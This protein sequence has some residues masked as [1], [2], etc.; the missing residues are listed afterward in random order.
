VSQA[1]LEISVFHRS[2]DDFGV[3]LRFRHPAAG[4]DKSA[5][6][7]LALDE[8]ALGQV[9][10]DAT[11]YGERLAA[12]LFASPG[13]RSFLDQTLAVA[14]SQQ[15]PLHLRLFIHPDATALHAL[16]WETLRLPGSATPL[17]TGEWVRFSRY[18]DS[19]GWRPTRTVERA[20]LRALVAVASPD[21]AGTALAEV[22]ID[23]ELAAA[24]AGLGDIP[25]VELAGRGQVTL[26]ALLARLR[27]GCDILYLAAHGALVDGEPQILLEREDGGRAWTAGSELAARL[28]E[29]ASPPSLVVLVSCQ[30]AGA[31]GQWLAQDGGAL[32]GLGPRL[33]A[34]GVPA[35]VAMQGNLSMDT[36][37]AF[38]PAF[39]RELRRDGQMA[40]AMAVARGAVRARPDW[41]MPVLYTRLED[42]RVFELPNA[43][44]DSLFD[45]PAL[46]QRDLPD[47][48]FHYLDWYPRED[49]EVFFG[50]GKEI[51]SLYDRVTSPDGDPI[52]LLYGQS[53]VGKS[54]VL[55]AGLR[56]RLDASHEVRYMRRDQEKGLLGTLAA[57][58]PIGLDDDLASAWRRLEAQ[59]DRPLLVVVDQVE[60]YFTRPNPKQPHEMA[61][62]LDA[63]QDLFGDASARPRG[64]IILGFRKEWLAEIDKRLAERAL[65]RAGVFLERLGRAGIAEVVAGP[66]SRSRLRSRYGLSVIDALPGMIADDLLADRESPVAPMLAILLADMWDAAKARSYDRPTFDEDLYHEF[67]TRGLSLNDFLG[68]QLRALAGEMPE[69]VD[70][71]L[72]LDLLAYHTTPLGTAEQRTLADLEQTYSHRLDVLPALVQQCQDLYLLVDPAKN[73]PGQPPA[74]RL[75]HD[76]LAP[77]VR[78]RFDESNAPGQ[79]ARR[80]LDGRVVEWRNGADGTIL[81]DIDLATIETGADGM[82]AWN[83]A[84]INMIDASREHRR[85]RAKQRRVQRA[86]GIGAMALIVVVLA[87]AAFFA[88]RSI[89][90]Q[91]SAEI[92]GA[93]RLAL[94]AK[95]AIGSDPESALLLAMEAANAHRS[96]ITTDA[97]REALLA[98]RVVERVN[99]GVQAEMNAAAFSAGQELFAVARLDGKVLLFDRQNGDLIRTLDSGDKTFIRDLAFSPQSS[100]H[101]GATGYRYQQGSL[102]GASGGFAKIWDVKSGA[103]VFSAEFAES[104]ND[105]D[106][107]SDMSTVV[108]QVGD[109]EAQ[110]WD[111]SSGRQITSRSIAPRVHRPTFNTDGSQI[112]AVVSQREI[113]VWDSEL[114]QEL[115]RWTATATDEEIT[116]LAFSPQGDISVM[117]NKGTVSIWDMSQIH[118]PRLKTRQRV[119]EGP[120]FDAVFSPNGACVASFG[121]S[122]QQAVVAT[123]TGAAPLR[124]IDHKNRIFAVAFLKEET[125]PN[126][127]L[128]PCGA[129]SLATISSDGTMLT[130]NIGPTREYETLIAHTQ[131]VE[132]VEFSD[133]QSY[134]ATASSDGTAQL[135]S[136]EPFRML[137]TLHHGDDEINA[138]DISP[139]GRIVVTAGED[140]LV[141]VWQ[142]STFTPLFPPMRGHQGPVRA[143]KF[144][145]FS[146]D[147]IAT[148]GDD[149]KVIL[150]DSHTGSPVPE[151]EW[152][153]SNLRVWSIDFNN[154]GTHMIVGTADGSSHI[155]DLATGDEKILSISESDYN[156]YDAAMK[157]DYRDVITASSDGMIRRWQIEPNKSIYQSETDSQLLGRHQGRAFSLDLDSTGTMLVSGGEDGRMFLWALPNAELVSTL[158]GG[159]VSINSVAFSPDGRYIAA[160]DEDG[161]VRIYLTRSDELI[162]LA[163]SRTTRPLTENE[164]QQYAIQTNCP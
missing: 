19:A 104:V 15:T 52:V 85:R 154:D 155:I 136:V 103:E 100:V 75:T 34:A 65:P 56:P 39:L 151:K 88:Q 106:M 28:G 59:S 66:T 146:G 17:A 159:G 58:L 128:V 89:I 101:L 162:Q 153:I 42:G 98:S 80:I 145:P 62:F 49:A 7:V 91:Q 121:E 94:S 53:G 110:L 72:A 102:D 13:L 124:L 8:A 92:T 99:H 48:P 74:S 142:A 46:P 44:D 132:D 67:R 139:D 112:A 47:K 108:V 120:V 63:L 26:S 25:T 2:A 45:L 160:G 107:S 71:G 12:Q 27:D 41:W 33:A 82:R 40:R 37:A 119:H 76:T 61:D 86:L 29:L 111:V 57:G 84:E 135:W 21:M 14:A 68:R 18:L 116:G 163:A 158:S 143:T 149:G 5:S 4:Q 81:D 83:T 133:D 134:L 30:S 24:R 9:Q 11:A 118:L 23:R 141:K 38:M 31:D 1:D 97:M 10:H 54:S 157:S 90:S 77:H 95:E 127:P 147:Q 87:I 152:Q 36:A 123:E 156:V 69:V 113:A 148:G 35:V 55:A 60:E 125:T 3:T 51:R 140:G 129:S 32:A 20:A 22:R 6:G 164:C 64:R 114:K 78:K 50:R 93:D 131:S 161:L 138:I 122:D 105:L 117:D 144:R 115:V 137:G 43:A 96:R 130:W 109:Y 73:Q 79:R 70:S 126:H 150:W 16:R